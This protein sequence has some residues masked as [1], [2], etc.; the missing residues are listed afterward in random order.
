MGMLGQQAFC[1][2]W[3]TCFAVGSMSAFQNFRPPVGQG[4]GSRDQIQRPRGRNFRIGGNTPRTREASQRH[5]R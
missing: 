4:P 1:L 5:L 3:P 2:G